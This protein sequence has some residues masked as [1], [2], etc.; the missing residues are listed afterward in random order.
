MADIPENLQEN[1]FEKDRS[2][3]DK[4]LTIILVILILA[5]VAVLVYVVVM[6]KQGEKFT[7]FYILGPGGM[8]GDYPTNMVIGD[9]GTVIVGV[10]NHEY[11]TINYSMALVMENESST[12]DTTIRLEHNE[13]WEQTIT[14]TPS[15][16]GD[17][18]KLQFLLFKENNKSV[19]YRDLHLWIDVSGVENRIFETSA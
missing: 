7:E 4:A 15:K 18:M 3:L 6:P 1:V 9:S 14:F 2:R 12:Y 8:A 19:P 13:T 16:V 10:V 17:D 11:A 5:S